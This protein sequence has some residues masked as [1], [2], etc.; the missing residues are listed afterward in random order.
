MLQVDKAE[1]DLA[2]IQAADK[3]ELDIPSGQGTELSEAILSPEGDHV[4]G[5]EVAT[6][7][8]PVDLG[9]LVALG[10]LVAVAHELEAVRKERDEALKENANMIHALKAERGASKE[11]YEKVLREKEV[12]YAYMSGH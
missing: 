4:L 8:S 1:L 11:E 5:D 12:L 2:S 10:E 7:M 6:G 9:Q 3:A